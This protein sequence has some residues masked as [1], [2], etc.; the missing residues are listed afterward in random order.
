MELAQ[1]LI[2]AFVQGITEF[3]PISSSAHLILPAQILAWPDQGLAFDVAVH[4]GSLLAVMGYFRQD[5][6]QIS[7][8]FLRSSARL[9]LSSSQQTDAKMAWYIIVATV[10]AGLAGLIFED[11]IELNLRSVTV[12][13]S[14]TLIFGLL[15][16]FADAYAKRGNYSGTLNWRAV[17]LIGLAQA[18]ALIPG[19]S[20][21]GIT[22]TAALLMG[23]NRELSARFSFL[24]S[25]P[26]ILAAG[27]LKFIELVQ[28]GTQVPWQ[29][30][31]AGTAVSGLTAYLCIYGF[32]SF[33]EKIGFMPFV[34]Y[35]LALAALLFGLLWL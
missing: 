14:T 1:A 34:I 11:F 13:A 32:I 27:G 3:L 4:V 19:T 12:I 6:W 26:L 21:S 31:V 9:P 2:L 18:L 22:M 10:P 29:H 20:R 5:L 30:I 16:W 24:L 8:A 7:L 35:R 25:V 17:I 23:L 28:T 15:L 33:I